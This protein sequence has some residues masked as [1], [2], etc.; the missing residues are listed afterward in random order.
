[1]ASLDDGS[2]APAPACGGGAGTPEL[3]SD[4]EACQSMLLK[5]SSGVLTR[6]QQRFFAICG[7]NLE[8]ADTEEA[9]RNSSKGVINLRNASE[10]KLTSGRFITLAAGNKG[11]LELQADSE[12]LAQVWHAELTK[13]VDARAAASLQVRALAMSLDA[14]HRTAMTQHDC[15]SPSTLPRPRCSR[16]ISSRRARAH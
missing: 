9:L 3:A 2:A 6:W 14:H 12:E 4:A 11:A 5:K 16:S 7:H 15:Y 1:M 13:F 8:Y 10:C